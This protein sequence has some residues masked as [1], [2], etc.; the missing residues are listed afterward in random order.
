MPSSRSLPPSVKGA[1]WRF[2][3]SNEALALAHIQ[4]HDVPDVVGRMLAQR[5]ITVENATHFLNPTLRH[6]LP[7]PLHLI[8]MEKAAK[9]LLLAIKKQETICIF[10]DY[11]V[12]GATSTAMLVRYLRSVGN[13]ARF[14]IPDR[15]LE[16]YGPSTTALLQLRKEGV[17]LVITVDCGTVAFEP[18]EAAAKAGLD[19]V[20][21]DHHLSEHAVPTAIAVVNPNRMDETSKERNLCAAGVT[22]LL[23]VALNRMLREEGFFKTRQEPD[24]LSLLD[25]AALGTVCDVMSL[26]NLNRAFVSQGLKIMAK[27][28]NIGLSALAD[29]GRMDGPPSVYHLGFILGPRIN[30]GGRVG[31]SHLGARL[32][33]TEDPEE[34][35]ALAK[36]LD[37]LNAER[38]QIEKSVLEEA[39]KL[40]ELQ[41]N[42]PVVT[43]AGKGWHPGVIGIVAGRIKELL[44]RPTAI[45][46]LD[47]GIGKASA[48]SIQGVDFGSA[49]T[50]ARLEGLLLA[51]GGHAM[52]GGFTVEE[53]FIPELVRFFNERLAADVTRETEEKIL[54]LDASLPLSALTPELM[55]SLEAL[56]PYGVGN[57]EPRF[58]C[59]D[60]RVVKADIVGEN[61]VRAIFTEQGAA[62]NGKSRLKA[63]AFRCSDS[64][65]GHT[66][67]YSKGKNL[68]IAGRLKMN[69]WQGNESVEM[70]IE[71][72]IVAD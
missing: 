49:I 44:G 25:L 50:A 70:Q 15:I 31:E 3:E 21:I 18:L 42:N 9:R 29:V 64:P 69:R 10:G 36:E 26:T 5:E 48:R 2:A 71:D 19:I 66:L 41:A 38:Q 55:Q 23:L 4:H 62:A 20:V 52:A 57:P 1:R 45:I 40:T 58:A 7:E 39:A 35:A 67:L 53:K 8:D 56:A 24:L 32:L 61:H 72:V 37:R 17:D 63:V 59:M 60:V 30:A 6:F 68:H 22:F 51:G 43:I 46:A 14:Y 65:L 16:G 33:S 12:D 34:A 11:D 27:R 47:K 54:T 13:D 28:G